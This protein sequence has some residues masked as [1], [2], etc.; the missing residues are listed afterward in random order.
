MIQSINQRGVMILVLITLL[1]LPSITSAQSGSPYMLTWSTID[2]GGGM[3]QTGSLSYT[4]GG[5]LGQPDAGPVLV[6]GGYALIGGFWVSSMVT[7]QY[8]YL[9]LVLRE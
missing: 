9:P 2:G 5:T 6:G 1:L 3:G 7:E 8:I 4:L